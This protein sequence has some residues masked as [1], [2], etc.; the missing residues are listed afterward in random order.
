MAVN[1]EVF[2]LAHLGDGTGCQSQS[3]GM[4]PS[5]TNKRHKH[6]L[7]AASEKHH[8]SH[9]WNNWHPIYRGGEEG[10]GGEKKPIWVAGNL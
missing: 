4:F 9:K 6:L 5:A 7:H 8:F 3:N 1:L 2:N 10:D